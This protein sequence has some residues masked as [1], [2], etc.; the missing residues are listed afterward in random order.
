[1]LVET[2]SAAFRNCVTNL[3]RLR[4]SLPH[5][6][7][8]TRTANSCARS[9]TLRFFVSRI[10]HD[11]CWCTLHHHHSIARCVRSLSIISYNPFSSRQLAR[12][13]CRCPPAQ[14]GSS[15]FGPPAVLP[16]GPSAAVAL[17]PS[18]AVPP[19][20]LRPCCLP[21][22]RLPLPNG[23]QAGSPSPHHCHPLFFC[24]TLLLAIWPRLMF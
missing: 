20:A 9:N 2:D 24:F 1:M 23:Q 19:S 16:S 4:H 15:P 22:F 8:S 11:V 5:V 18:R 12:T 6:S 3:P 13:V 14:Q 7:A 17:R 21:A 10:A